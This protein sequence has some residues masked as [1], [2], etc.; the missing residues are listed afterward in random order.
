MIIA[1]FCFILTIA[2]SKAQDFF[3]IDDT[4]LIESSMLSSNSTECIEICTDQCIS[5]VDV[6]QCFDDCTVELCDENVVLY[7]I[8]DIEDHTVTYGIILICICLFFTKKLC[9]DTNR[10]NHFNYWLI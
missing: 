1:F 5:D 6:Y 2:R 3:I 4:A 9:Y 10:T 7:S 8:E